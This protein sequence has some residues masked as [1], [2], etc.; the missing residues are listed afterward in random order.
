[1][2]M[3]LFDQKT[4]TKEESKEDK[5]KRIQFMHNVYSALSRD[6]SMSNEEKQK[7]VTGGLICMNLSAKEVLEDIENRYTSS[8]LL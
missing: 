8:N 2:Y 7:I 6:P 3:K 5:R 1:M 4:D